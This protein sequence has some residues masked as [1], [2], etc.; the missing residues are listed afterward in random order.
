MEE[1][2]YL[3]AAIALIELFAL[4][5]FI[6]NYFENRGELKVHN[7]KYTEME[8]RALNA[9]SDL[10]QAQIKIVMQ[11]DRIASLEQLRKEQLN[12]AIALEKDN[13]KLRSELASIKDK[14]S[15]KSQK[16]IKGKFAA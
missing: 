16:R 12:N 2:L 4:I 13:I 9:E 14:Y 6:C 10:T 7:E 15:R 11:D 1:L 3:L 8:S 5:I